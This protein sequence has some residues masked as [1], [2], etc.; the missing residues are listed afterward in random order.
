MEHRW[1]DDDERC[2]KCGDKDWFA[3]PNCRSPCPSGA[4]A[5]RGMLDD[6]EIEKLAEQFVDEQECWR[7]DRYYHGM[8]IIAF[9]RAIERRAIE[10]CFDDEHETIRSQAKEIEELVA[11]IRRVIGDHNPPDDCYSTGPFHGDWQDLACPA[12]E[13]MRAAASSRSDA[14]QKKVAQ[15]VRGHA[16][17]EAD[18][19]MVATAAGQELLACA[20]DDLVNGGTE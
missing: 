7:R 19:A 10:W 6:N 15:V 3:G 2:L 5:R 20:I 11:A 12:C 18:R 14:T 16:C 8:N 9:A 1:D 17:R 4:V 13:A